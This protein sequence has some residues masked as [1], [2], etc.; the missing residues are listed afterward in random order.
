MKRRRA[1]FC[2]NKLFLR[3]SKEFICDYYNNQD[4]SKLFLFDRSEDCVFKYYSIRDLLS[5]WIQSSIVN[6]CGLYNF[7]WKCRLLTPMLTQNTTNPTTSQTTLLTNNQITASPLNLKLKSSPK[8]IP[9]ETHSQSSSTVS[10]R[11]LALDWA[12]SIPKTK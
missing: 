11:S 7:G 10:L 8:L 5:Y 6:N 3:S 1:R 9:T 4:E 2:N 12:H